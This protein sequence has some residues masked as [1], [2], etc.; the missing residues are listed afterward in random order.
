MDIEHTLVQLIKESGVLAVKAGWVDRY[1]DSPVS[2]WCD[3]HAPAGSADPM[4]PFVQYLF[5]TG[6]EHQTEVTSN[7]YPE[8]VQEIFLNEE[9]GFRS[10]LELMHSGENLIKNM[11][12][13]A[14][15]IGLE[16]R[17]DVLV[18]VDGV[19]SKL[20]SHSYR[21]VEI[22]L[23]KNIRTCHILQAAA[24]NRVLGQVQGYQ[25]PDFDIVNRDWNVQTISM[26]DVT[27]KLDEAMA[28]IRAIIA[29]VELEPCYGAAKWPWVSFVD[30]LAIQRN[31]VSL[32]PGV[33]QARRGD[34]TAAGFETVVDVAEAAMS[35]LTNIKG[36]GV[37]TAANFVS[38][39][40]AIISGH[41]VS[42]G[43]SPEVPLGKT[44]VF[45]DLEGTDTPHT[46]EGLEVTNYLIGA[47]VRSK[48]GMAQYF[49]FFAENNLEEK[50]NL[51]AFL[52]WAYSL[53]DPVFYHWHTY[54]RTHVAKMSDFYGIQPNLS[55]WVTSRMVDLS[56]LVT[57]AFAFPCYGQGLKDIAKSLGFRW[58]QDDVDALGSVVLYLSYVGSGGTDQAARHKI[59]DYNEDDCL[60][61]MH[62][63]DWLISQKS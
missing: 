41:P 52:E 3:I 43:P 20:G 57:S 58:R 14:R 31:D 5:D 46:P 48:D 30:N 4:Q 23:A 53:D 33:G 45:F 2:F 16:G 49:S 15:S 39:A 50:A 38:S 34:M 60:A 11:P 1:V 47:V 36:I 6:N 59:L 29:G 10:T 24:Y 61:T 55:E 19:P 28:A 22:K 12:L 13:L 8:A 26:S 56:P 17:P 9:E 62:V 44:D 37:K 21:V 42:R 7:L 18:K 32:L 51:S 27:A 25:P 63:F 54:E 35:E 40:Q